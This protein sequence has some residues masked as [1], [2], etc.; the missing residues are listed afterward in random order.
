[1]TTSKKSSVQ[2]HSQLDD[3]KLKNKTL[4]KNTLLELA[5]IEDARVGTINYIFCSDEYVLELNKKFLDHDYYTDILSFPMNTDPLEG[6]IF[7]SVERVKENAATFNTDFTTELFRVIAHGML[8]FLGYDD[9][10][11]ENIRMMR[12]KENEFI[13]AVREKIE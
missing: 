9:H 2:F 5:Q 12:E 4:L 1:M 6:D 13:R 10:T 8:H 11:E 7:I 3:F